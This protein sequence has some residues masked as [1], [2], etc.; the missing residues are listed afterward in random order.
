MTMSRRRSRRIALAAGLLLI[1]LSFA[2]CAPLI[3]GAGAVAAYGGYRLFT[4][5]RTT[6]ELMS[7]ISISHNIKAKLL[8]EPGINSLNIHVDSVE[9]EIFLT[10]I[11]P[12]K[13]VSDKAMSIAS[14]EKGVKKVTNNLKIKP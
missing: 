1:S 4:D 14:A 13:E 11:V 2:A 12:T 5:P 9:G 7:D 6:D 10:G 8:A 3:I